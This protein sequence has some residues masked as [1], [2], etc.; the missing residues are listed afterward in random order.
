MPLQDDNDIVRGLGFVTLYAAYVEEGIDDCAAVVL[1]AEPDPPKR[2]DRLSVGERIR[3]LQERLA[4]RGALPRDL[5]RLRELLIYVADLFERRNEVLRERI[6]SIAHRLPRSAV[7]REP[8]AA[9][10][11][12]ITSAEL[13]AL[14]DELFTTLGPLHH[15]SANALPRWCAT[16][17]T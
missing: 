14:A 13:Y 15:A 9:A 6:F 8:D 12:P 16:R 1:A 4:S 11:E 2:F 10:A 3:Y 17:E 5:L 7:A